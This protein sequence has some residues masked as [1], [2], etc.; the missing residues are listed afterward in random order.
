MVGEVLLTPPNLQAAPSMHSD[1][2]SLLSMP[3]CEALGLKLIDMLANFVSKEEKD[4][5]TG[6]FVQKEMRSL[7]GAVIVVIVVL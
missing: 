2:N 6:L 5:S 1:L 3:I 7:R 4:K